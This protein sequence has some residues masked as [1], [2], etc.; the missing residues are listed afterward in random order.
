MDKNNF[1]PETKILHLGYNCEWSENSVTTPLLKT[2]TYGFV[3]PQKGKEA[4]ANAMGGGDLNKILIYSRVNHADAGI[5]EKR[6]ESIEPDAAEAAIFNTGMSAITTTFAAIIK[7]EPNKKVIACTRTLYGG[8]YQ[9]LYESLGKA[10]F[11]IVELDSDTIISCEQLKEIGDKLLALYI[12]APANPTLEMF[13]IEALTEAAKKASPGCFTISDNTFM[14]IYQAGFKIS[15]CLDLIVYSATKFLGGHSDLLG[16]VVL[17]HEKSKDIMKA[18]KGERILFGTILQPSECNS[19]ITRIS[20]YFIRMREETER[21]QK[22]A[23]HLNGL[24]SNKIQKI[25]YPLLFEE[26][27][28][29]Y[30]IY[31]KQCSGSSSIMSIYLNSDEEGTYRFLQ[32]VADSGIYQLAVSLGSVETLIE[33]PATMTHSEMPKEILD[34]VGITENLIRLSVGLEDPDDLICV[35]EDALSV[36]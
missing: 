3:T 7:M 34:R 21:A 29:N 2:S 22:I 4:F 35:F 6:L 32:K 9:Y 19:L 5:L 18:I 25:L 27:S 15:G 24:K 13:D 33:H 16:G 14:G 26:G 10:G 17:C 1:S 36:L 30:E 31:N 20:T 12:E 23:L 8:T 28:K 11:T